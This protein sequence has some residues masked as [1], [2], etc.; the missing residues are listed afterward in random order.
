MTL[1]DESLLS[2]DFGRTLIHELA[3]ALPRVLDDD[4]LE[5]LAARLSPHLSK[6]L[7]DNQLLTTAGAAK[8]A[9]VHVETVRRAIRAGDLAVAARIGRSPRL[10][11]LAVDAWLAE[12]SRAGPATR[13]L[14]TRRS[15]P[16]ARADEF[17]LGAAFKTIT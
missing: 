10:T 7:A 14:R 12:T 13:Q 1:E 9:Q 2:E 5:E 4:A 17:S 8:R 16:M 11:L 6:P 15:R 3:R